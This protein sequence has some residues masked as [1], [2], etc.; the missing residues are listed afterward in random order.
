MGESVRFD[1]AAEYY[2][3]TRV[4]TDRAMARTVELLVSELRD[5]GRVLEVG[6]GTGLVAWPLHEAGLELAGLDVS[7]PMLG[8]LVE[9]AGGV[10]PFP[11]VLGDATRLPF[12][13]DAFG[14]AYLRWVLHLVP[15]W[16]EAVAEVVRVVA[17]GGVVL[18]NHG[19]FSGVGRMIRSRMEELVGRSLTPV[20][21]DWNG[22]RELEAEME[23]LGAGHRELPPI[24]EGG[25]EPLATEVEGIEANRY[26]WTWGLSDEERLAAV[27]ELRPWLEERFGD[28]HAPHPHETEIVW[29]AYDLP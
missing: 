27:A 14:A 4:T 10:G 28:L 7:A 2:D 24:V 26:S 19:G 3:R 9:K 23:R 18:V 29:H 8:K 20:G 5:R 6:V 16:R 11:L 1:R 15:A 21:L 22:W 12:G 13:D 25:E 17:S